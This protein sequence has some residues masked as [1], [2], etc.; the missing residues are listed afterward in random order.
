VRPS[1]EALCCVMTIPALKPGL[2][3]GIV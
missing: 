2:V 3:H 1:I